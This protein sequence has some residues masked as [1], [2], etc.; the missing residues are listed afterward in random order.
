MFSVGGSYQLGQVRTEVRIHLSI[1]RCGL[2]QIISFSLSLCFSPYTTQYVLSIYY[3][4][5]T[6]DALGIVRQMKCSLKELTTIQSM[7]QYLVHNYYV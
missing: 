5:S 7:K 2:S 1:Q 6:S 4:S 3:M